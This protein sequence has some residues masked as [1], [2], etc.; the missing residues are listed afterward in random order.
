MPLSDAAL[1]V[2]EKQ[3]AIRT[4]EFVFAAARGI[5]HATQNTPAAVL[6]R[7]GRDALTAHPL[8]VLRLVRR[9]DRL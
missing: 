4:N 8:D 2:L 7:L 6:K 9:A 1:A 3:Q 5:G